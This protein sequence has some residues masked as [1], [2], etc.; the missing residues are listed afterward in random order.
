LQR[1][2]AETVLPVL[3]FFFV[4]GVELVVPGVDPLS[5]L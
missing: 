3:H 2:A 1:L 4:V 5:G